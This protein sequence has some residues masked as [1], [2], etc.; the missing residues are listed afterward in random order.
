LGHYW[1]RL[2]PGGEWQAGYTDG[3]EWWLPGESA[4]LDPVEI[5]PRIEPPG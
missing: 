5:G 1:V 4:S 2:V 3:M